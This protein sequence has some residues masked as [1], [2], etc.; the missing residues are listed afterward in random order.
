MNRAARRSF[1]LILCG[2]LAATPLAAQ[3]AEPAPGNRDPAAG[4]TEEALEDDEKT[5][6]NEPPPSPDRFDPSEE[7]SL[8]LPVSFP[9][10][11]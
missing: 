9:V 4:E 6:R 8:D 5:E 1:L 10:D 2:V 11:I 7:I 3:Q